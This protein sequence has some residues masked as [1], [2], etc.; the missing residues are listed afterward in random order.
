[1]LTERGQQ[2]LALIRKREAEMEAEAENLAESFISR[3]T[4]E[5]QK[6]DFRSNVTFFSLTSQT[7]TAEQ[8]RAIQLVGEKLGMNF[9]RCVEI[10]ERPVPQCLHR[11][12]YRMFEVSLLAFKQELLIAAG[13]APPRIV[14][15]PT[16][17][18]KKTRKASSR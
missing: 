9:A 2:I 14:P 1:M 3:L 17:Q 5:I 13:E 15:L 10:I 16:H 6:T 12:T 7:L 18:S 11:K 8:E 4:Y